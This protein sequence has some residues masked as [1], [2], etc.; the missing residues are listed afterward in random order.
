[1]TVMEID[2]EFIGQLEGQSVLTGYV[3]MDKNGVLGESGVTVATGVDLGQINKREFGY[4]ILTAELV[5]KLQFYI[6]LKG[7][8]AV[9]ALAT[10]PLTLTKE[11]SDMLDN[12]DRSPLLETLCNMW[13]MATGEYLWDLPSTAQ[14]VI[15]S[16]AFQYGPGLRRTCPRFWSACIQQNWEK[17]IEELRNFE[18]KYPTRRGKEADYLEKG[19]AKS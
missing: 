13:Y 9:E 5:S 1:M 12:E 7:K 11:E 4:F 15:A 3:P 6:G 18:D 16:V 19:L 8:E 14:T 2:W 17:T 10:T